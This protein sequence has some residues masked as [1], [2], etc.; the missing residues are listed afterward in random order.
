MNHPP[1]PRSPQSCSGPRV[2]SKHASPARRPRS[3]YRCRLRRHLSRLPG[4]HRVSPNR[5]PPGRLG[6]FFRFAINLP[7]FARVLQRYAP[8]IIRLSQPGAG[9]ISACPLN[10][11][12]TGIK[13]QTR[14]VEPRQLSRVSAAQ[15]AEHGAVSC[16]VI[17]LFYRIFARQDP[18]LPLISAGC[19]GQSPY[20]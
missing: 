14:A 2:A 13:R 5:I 9:T 1:A 11:S 18:R 15:F 12:T 7:T 10:Q 16:S 3:R 8:P 6:C 19:D 4:S 20:D 17:A